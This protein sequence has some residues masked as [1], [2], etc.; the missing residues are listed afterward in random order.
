MHETQ[1]AGGSGRIGLGRWLRLEW[2]NFAAIPYLAAIWAF[3]T[4]VGVITTPWTVGWM[5]LWLAFAPT[6]LAIGYFLMASGG[7]FTLAASLLTLAAA[8]PYFPQALTTLLTLGGAIFLGYPPVWIPLALF[9]AT[10]CGIYTWYTGG[11]GL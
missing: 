11:I 4:Y 7:T 1:R 6:A 3:G 9:I 5:M 2:A 10:V 8:T